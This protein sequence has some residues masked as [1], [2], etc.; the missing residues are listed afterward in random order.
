MNA[1][2]ANRRGVNTPVY[3]SIT[4]PV[5]DAHAP[6]KMFRDGLRP[7][8][9]L[10]GRFGH[11]NNEEL[12][13]RLSRMEGGSG[14]V[15][16]AS[17]MC[18]SFT[19]IYALTEIGDHIVVSSRI[20]G[21]TRGQLGMHAKK[22]G[23]NVTV[24]DITDLDAVARACTNKTKFLFVE[25]VSNPDMVV[26][27]ISALAK[28]CHV[29]GEGGRDI[30]LI[31]D[32][33]FTPLIARPILF[34]ADFVYHS[35]TKI[36]SGRSDLMGGAVIASPKRKQFLEG[37]A[38]PATGEASLIGGIIHYEVAQEIAE[39]F[40]QLADRVVEASERAT[41]LA[42]LFV[43]AGL[44]VHYPLLSNLPAHAEL[45]NQGGMLLGGGVFSV[46]FS[47]EEEGARFVDYVKDVV[48][49]DP[50]FGAQ[51]LAIPAVSLGSAH[52]YVWCTTEA[53]AQGLV[54]KWPALPFAPVPF[55]FVRI[56]V[57]YMGD[58]SLVLQSFEDALKAL[59]YS[60]SPPEEL[61]HT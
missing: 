50:L 7:G 24:V 34:G 48:V 36:L 39:R 46:A 59:N 47:S 21:G 58:R 32:N 6:G 25:T 1:E 2:N 20:Y 42:K 5:T 37:M 17:G 19:L 55:G 49:H 35:L 18:A 23:L 15:L 40:A 51:P 57:G 4:F 12:A 43:R 54:T 27:H 13:D 33:T 10:Y 9:Q 29:H 26:P 30:L 61:F 60:I 11:P 41:L 44:Q 45:S 16:F 14:A 56:A 53:R 52:T 22:L 28:I 31:V 38:H 3:K 8:E